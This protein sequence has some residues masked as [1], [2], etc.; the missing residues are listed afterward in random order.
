MGAAVPRRP[1]IA[2]P[3]L[4]HARSP[5][6][7]PGEGL[8][9]QEDFMNRRVFLG[10]A[11]AA[12]MTAAAQS[13]PGSKSQRVEVD[14]SRVTGPFPHYWENTVGSDR[15]AVAFRSQWQDDLRRVR[16]LTGMKSV[17][18]HGLFCDEMGVVRAMRE[19]GPEFSF[20]YIAEVFDKMLELGV[21]PF[22]ELSFMP[23]RLAS[24]TRTVFFYRGNITPP[25]KMEHWTQLVG[26]FTAQCVK[27]YGIT[28]VS[29]WQFECWNEP[30]LPFFWAGTQ[31]Q[32]FDLYRNTAAAVKA[33]DRRIPVGGPSTAQVAWLPAFIEYCAAHDAPL[34]FVST[35]IYADDPQQ[36]IFGKANLW[37]LE[38][39]MPKAFVQCREQIRSSRRPDLPL[40]ITEWASQNPA[41]IAQMIRDCAG[42]VDTMSYWTF[43]NVFEEM[44]PVTQFFNSTFGMI[45]QRGVARPS[46]HAFTLLHR[47]GER[48]LFAGD[49]P[50]LA[51]RRAD[52]SR[53]IL[54]WNLPSKLAAQGG[55]IPGVAGRAADPLA[56]ARRE[57]QGEPLTL[58]LRFTNP[59]NPARA[60][61]TRVDMLRGSALPA[62]QEMGSPELPAAAEVQKLRQEA[63]LPAAER[64]PVQKGELTIELPPSGLALIELNA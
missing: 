33:V 29:Q 48:K 25:A 58:T 35:H 26:A 21:R 3:A 34:D 56:Q 4:V 36:N 11:G 14:L 13:Q 39:V 19:A 57:M 7:A 27:R 18:C 8:S 46:L 1:G 51:T 12:A 60:S 17:R 32:Y 9:P 64:R 54:V 49:G 37:P 52:G 43:S 45:G 31:E 42:L 61:V 6:R 28:E 40:L 5:W 23:S 50:I 2:S 59:G 44:G 53:A 15:T 55:G 63:E 62:W 20:L 16:Q 41:F 10:T 38:Q 47:L 24:G 30:N 22:V